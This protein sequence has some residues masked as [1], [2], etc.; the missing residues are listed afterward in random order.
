MGEDVKVVYGIDFIIDDK[1]TIYSLHVIIS[2]KRGSSC[3]PY[4]ELVLEVMLIDIC[5]NGVDY[6]YKIH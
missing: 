5:Y 4:E 3:K 1:L 6:S 2:N